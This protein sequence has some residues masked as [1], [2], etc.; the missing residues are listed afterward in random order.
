MV[1]L[2]WGCL[3]VSLPLVAARAGGGDQ[4][5]LVVLLAGLSPLAACP[6]ALATAVLGR[7]ALRS[8]MPVEAPDGSPPQVRP[9]RRWPSRTG[10]VVAVIL[11]VADVSW[12]LPSLL[13]D[14]Q[15]AAS[16]APR[17]RLL[18][19]NLEVGGADTGRV[20][21][22]V[23]DRRVDVLVLLELTP[24]AVQRLQG[25]GL[26]RSLPH[27]VVQPRS[28]VGGTGIWTRLPMARLEPVAGTGFAMPRVRLTLTG[29]GAVELTAVHVSAPL[30]MGTSSWRRDFR[31]LGLAVSARPD[32]QVLAG[33]FNATR[34]HA[35]F[36][37]LLET[38]LVDAADVEGLAAWP[39]WT[40]PS[41][42]TSNPD[43]LNV[44]WRRVRWPGG[45]DLVRGLVRPALRLDHV[46]VTPGRERVGSVT[47]VRVAGTDHRGVLVELAVPAQ[48]V[49]GVSDR[50]GR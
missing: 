21:Q 38:G 23:Q 15:A 20:V 13:P 37:H 44:V 12:S 31:L 27:S 19:L 30:S 5:L 32:S 14:R 10:A 16:S 36:R 11:L 48:P 29:G 42:A 46:L 33:D 34:D 45:P 17:I 28:G 26:E 1:T 41:Q 4:R 6:L 18:T 40:W 3:L 9:R 7:R 2:A 43:W 25:F 50:A 47:A 24:E 39:G 49:Q 8:A 22:L 35:P